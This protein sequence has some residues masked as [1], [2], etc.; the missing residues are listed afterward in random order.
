[1][2]EGHFLAKKNCA[3]RQSIAF[4]ARLKGKDSERKW[5]RAKEYSCDMLDE[6]GKTWL[7]A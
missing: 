4:Q 7:C 1:M 2:D 3:V 6:V 5:R